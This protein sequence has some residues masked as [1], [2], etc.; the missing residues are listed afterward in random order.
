MKT[1]ALA[2]TL[3][4]LLSA[5]DRQVATPAAGASADSS[6]LERIAG[7]K[8]EMAALMRMSHRKGT[9]DDALTTLMHDSTIAAA[10]FEVVASDDRFA[11]ITA[12]GSP[13]APAGTSPTAAS[14]AAAKK[15]AAAKSTRAT[16]TARTTTTARRGDVLDQAENTAK[17]ANERL[18]QAERI[19]RE[20][21]EAKRKVEVI[22]GR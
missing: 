3:L 10:V 9:F 12:V 4:L 6:A 11:A 18:E 1:I 16:T 7:D 13:V 21:E 2:G 8:D 17:K 20:A 14:A 15:L 19:K 5:C 22:L